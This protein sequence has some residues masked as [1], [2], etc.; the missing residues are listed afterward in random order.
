MKTK[1]IHLGVGDIVEGYGTVLDISYHRS[2]EDW[3]KGRLK[4]ERAIKVTFN[5][6]IATFAESIE[7]NVL[8]AGKQ[9]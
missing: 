6:I 3:K 8:E 1:V 9:T 5:G 2:Y 7:L 4:S